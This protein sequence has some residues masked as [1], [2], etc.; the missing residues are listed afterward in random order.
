[1]TSDTYY[2]NLQDSDLANANPQE[3]TFS[4]LT[5]VEPTQT[6]LVILAMDQT[7]PGI[8]EIL[9]QNKENAALTTAMAELAIKDNEPA[10]MKSASGQVGSTLLKGQRLV[11]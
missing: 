3:S 8:R 4:T 9:K 1:M 10:G 11:F 2:V 7:W 6:Y 5:A